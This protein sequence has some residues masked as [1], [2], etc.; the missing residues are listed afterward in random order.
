MSRILSNLL[1]C[2]QELGRYTHLRSADWA[3]IIEVKQQH[4]QNKVMPM[5]A[6]FPLALRW[7]I[8]QINVIPLA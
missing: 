4:H 7:L 2:S 5:M 1:F 3:I 6:P 8:S